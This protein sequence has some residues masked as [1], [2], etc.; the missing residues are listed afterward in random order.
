V[1]GGFLAGMDDALAAVKA[2]AIGPVTITGHSLGGARA[3]IAAAK[4][5]VRRLPVVKVVTFGSPK[6]AFGNLARVIQK[7]GVEHVSYR[8]RN[9]PVP[10]VPMVLPFWQHTEGWT[11][12][13]GAPDADE[14]DALR[15]HSI[16]RYIGAMQAA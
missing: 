15:D 4:M 3:R 2:A 8:N 9:D 7:S 11:V 12:V 1:H 13:D 14:L 16:A 10:L 5:L 6:P